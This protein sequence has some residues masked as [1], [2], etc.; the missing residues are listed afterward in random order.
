MMEKSNAFEYID[1]SEGERRNSWLVHGVG[2]VLIV[3]SLFSLF[4]FVMRN[5]GLPELM[6]SAWNDVLM[7]AG[8]I[9]LL[10]LQRE[11][12]FWGYHQTETDLPY[13]ALMVFGAITVL[14]NGIPPVVAV[15][16][17]RVLG[18][19]IF[20]YLI[21]FYGLKNAGSK[22]FFREL[23]NFMLIAAALVALYGIIQYVLAFETPPNWIDRDMEN[24]RTRVFSTIGNPNALGA[25]MA[26]FLPISISLGIRRG[27][28]FKGRSLYIL[29][30]IMMAFT[31]LF[32][33]SRGA[34]IGFAAGM[35]LL[36]VLKDKR[37]I[38]LFLILLVLMPIVLPDAVTNRLFHAFSPEYIERSA[39]A[40][41]LYY[42]SQAFDR[43]MAN[44]LF[45]TGVGSFGDSVAIRHDMP[46][47][48]WV[49]NHY[50]KTGAEM[51]IVG[52]GILLWLL[53]T[54]FVKGF[55][56]LS[57]VPQGY[58]QEFVR[59]AMA[60]LFAVLVQNGTASIFEVLVVGSYFWIIVG[61]IHALPILYQDEDRANIEEAEKAKAQGEGDST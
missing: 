3:V 55:K 51:G 19:A 1:N 13:V 22:E 9:L 52:L 30:A 25:Y 10:V 35:G 48:V 47:A 59:G 41:R 26:L 49:D 18:Q 7:L 45:G 54:V 44:P 46:G 43:M 27:L 28:S 50:L 11:Q 53:G 24:I 14:V 42:W 57:R 31:L 38:V 2:V 29:I 16:G 61:M 33:F 6:A 32:T 21:V 40:G 56:A 37:F 12:K 58:P 34:W 60:G 23:V 4:D 8:F 15:D 17:L 36:M 39:E 20:W 5:F